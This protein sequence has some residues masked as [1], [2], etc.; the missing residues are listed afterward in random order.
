MSDSNKP[1]F[2]PYRRIARFFPLI[3]GLLEGFIGT[4]RKDMLR[5]LRQKG[6]SRILDLGCG[7]GDL[8]R[9]FADEGFRPVGLDLSRGMLARA[10][11]TADRFPFFPLVLGDA[12]HLP[13]KPLFDAAVMRFVF[14]EM[15]AGQREV[16]WKELLR[17]IRPGGLLILI[18]F[19]VPEER[20][21]YARLGAFMIHFIEHR[22][23]S[24]HP[25]HYLNFR[26]L[27]DKGGASA[28]FARQGIE[29]AES[30]RYFGGS[31]GLI[32][33]RMNG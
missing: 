12:A 30:R 17:V 20:G 14:H 13:F 19:T 10:R 5:L 28:W 27:M 26:D 16:V 15:D 29:V 23:V 25:P 1:Q 9:I 18:D 22:M 6:Q 2:D 11:I 31:I 32:A 21:L 24:I 4:I 33:V 3:G 7:T 8:S